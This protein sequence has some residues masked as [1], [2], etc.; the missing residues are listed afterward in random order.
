MMMVVMVLCHS[1][2]E[3]II[4]TL[5]SAMSSYVFVCAFCVGLSWAGLMWQQ[6][7]GSLV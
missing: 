5:V 3:C 7:V 6:L 1:R 2:D 4:A